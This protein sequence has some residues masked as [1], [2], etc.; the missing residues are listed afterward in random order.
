MNERIR[1]NL[2]NW[3][4]VDDLNMVMIDLLVPSNILLDCSL[5]I[6]KVAR[7][8]C[9]VPNSGNLLSLHIFKSGTP[10]RSLIIIAFSPLTLKFLKSQYFAAF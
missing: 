1:G 6:V 2:L 10:S 9:F 3:T 8:C 5:E 4:I 7:N